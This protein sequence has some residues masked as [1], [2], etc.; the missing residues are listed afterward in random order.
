[1]LPSSP[2][3]EAVINP[4]ARDEVL[5]FERCFGRKPAVAVPPTFIWNAAVER[6]WQEVGVQIVVTPG[7]R[8]EARDGEGQPIAA[9]GA[10]RNGERSTT[11][12]RYVVRDD[13]FE[14]HKGHR[15]ERALAAL[16]GKTR[17][18]R[19]TLLETHRVN[20]LDA[21]GRESALAELES[22]LEQALRRYPDIAFI[23]TERLANA[24]ERSDPAW[25]EDGWG[26]RLHVFIERLWTLPRMRKLMWIT[27]LMLPVWLIWLLSG[28][29]K[30]NAD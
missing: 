7:R 1:M 3:E 26:V 28:R 17:L 25:I 15:A 10:I 8:F 27:T 30:L 18:G 24:M 4:A 5:L 6:A 20:F 9:G 22:L 11:G 16:E 19:P 2:L 14:P 23:S 29:N 13:Y 12:V 21:E